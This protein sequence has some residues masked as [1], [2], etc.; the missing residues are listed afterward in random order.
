[1][2]RDGKPTHGNHGGRTPHPRELFPCF[3][4][5]VKGGSLAVE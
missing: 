3:F 1:M 2:K 4:K 5:R